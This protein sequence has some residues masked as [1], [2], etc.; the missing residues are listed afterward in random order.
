MNFRKVSLVTLISV[1][2]FVYG[3]WAKTVEELKAENDR[4]KVLMESLAKAVGGLGGL[5]SL[6]ASATAGAATSSSTT[7]VAPTTTDESTPSD[8]LVPS[9]PR[10]IIASHGYSDSVKVFHMQAYHWGKSHEGL[11]QCGPIRCEWYNSFH[12]KALKE[13]LQ[14]TDLN[15]LESLR[16]TTLSLYNIHYL[17][18]KVRLTR[19]PIC[20]VNTDLT[21]AESEESKVRYG[22][23]FE[24]FKNFDGFSTPHPS[25]DLPRVYQAAFLNNSDL[26]PISN[27]SSLIKGASFVASDCH[28]RDSANANRDSIVYRIRM[29]DYRV[30]GLGR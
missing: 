21:M 1:L 30:D 29:E 18:E 11:D 22:Q 13:N 15:A 5:S 8:P 3:A 14:A 26:L 4:L 27:F 10:P 2:A 17:W 23:L 6:T 28:K 12:V 16:T 9:A 20:E 19:P 25:A 7:T 24:G